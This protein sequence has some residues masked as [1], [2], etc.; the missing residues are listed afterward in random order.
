MK[1]RFLVSILLAAG[2]AIAL[3][4]CGDNTAG[5]TCG[6][7]TTLS[8]DGECVANCGAGTT[9]ENGM[10]VPNVACGAGTVAIGDECVPDG[11]M[12]CEQ[13]TVYDMTVGGC[14]LD[15]SA[16][17]EGTVLVGDECVNEDDALTAD[18][19]EAAEPNETM[20]AGMFVVPA[21]GEQ[22]VIHGCITPK[23]GGVADEDIWIMTASAPS[24]LEITADG[25]H[26]LAAAF[27]V[28]DGSQNPL[29]AD[30]Q[31]LGVNLTGD[32]SKRQVYLPAA[33]TY[34]LIMDDS[35]SLILGEAAGGP[36]TCYFTT[37][38]QV[39]LP[40]ATT[41]GVPQTASTDDGNVKV[42]T[43]NASAR[44]QIIDVNAN[45]ASTTL[46]PSFVAIRNNAL[47][48]VASD[49]GF[50]PFW[51]FGGLETTNDTVSI[52]W[53]AQINFGIEP[54]PFTLDNFQ[55]DAPELVDGTPITLTSKNGTIAAAPYWEPN[56]MWFDVATAGQIV[57]FNLVS[58]E[59]VQMTIFGRDIFNPDGSGQ[60]IATI[61]SSAAGRTSFVNEFVKFAQPGRYYFRTF[62]ATGAVAGDTYT[63][64]ST[65]TN[66]TPTPVTFGTPLTAQTLPLGSAL[67]SYD[68]TA[69][70]VWTSM[71]VTN[72]TNF[73][74]AARVRIYNTALNG[75]L[76]TTAWPQVQAITGTTTAATLN[77][78][79]EG[80]TRDF[81]IRVDQ[82]G[83][84]GT[85]PT[86]DL[87]VGQRAFV[88]LG[89]V[90]V[91]TPLTRTGEVLGPTGTPPARNWYLV[92]SAAGNKVTINVDP[93]ATIDPALEF[94]NVDETLNGS[95]IDVGGNGTDENG[96]RAIAGANTFLA[97]SLRQF[98][99]TPGTVDLNL[100]ATPSLPFADICAAGTPLPAP[101]NGAGDDEFSAVQTLPAGFSFFGTPVTEYIVAANGFLVFG[102]TNP[103]CS[104]GCFSN[105]AIPSATQP[106]GIVAPHWDDLDTISACVAT[107]A[108]MTAV[109]VQWTG[110][111]YNT[112]TQVQFQA[113]IHND[114][115]VDFIYGPNH[116]STGSSAT[117]GIENLAGTVGQ[118]I[119]TGTF[120]G[121][122]ESLDS[123]P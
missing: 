42:Y 24:V 43:F 71:A 96:V 46:T 108:G 61:D 121:T 63:I 70:D 100:N 33:G 4:A 88:D 16:C 23:A 58:D 83:T 27:A 118:A 74:S 82:S 120:G 119:T 15:P 122:S 30:W 41:L 114:G 93:A 69:S 32:T 92:R 44:G 48:G 5:T 86:F 31:R 107:N 84:A 91:G 78:I 3:P 106:N 103:T 115:K 89:T 87:S 14:V 37:I 6:D 65:R 112:T 49:Q 79:V 28:I 19:E 77:R 57:H 109:T 12:I 39:A 101:F 21:I 25:V 56:Y 116:Q 52:I 9:L 55:V 117:V 94:R 2:A 85:G 64:T 110:F 75:W 68:V 67:Y 81:L 7:G 38:R 34:L 97:F 22:R 53:D 20:G 13:G 60:V 102:N 17:A 90:T 76:G 95:T 51:T 8:D 98:S 40:A 26:G 11:T 104:F 113:V 18:T 62:D 35:R 50:P 123:E 54:Q 29:L 80:E 66:V 72:A 73:G 10:C 45:T 36:D 47:Q 99:L 1:P 59:A 111:L 105:G